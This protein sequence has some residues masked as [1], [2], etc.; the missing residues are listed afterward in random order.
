MVPNAM[1]QN[2]KLQAAVDVKIIGFA[3]PDRVGQ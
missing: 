1:Q 2:K 3:D